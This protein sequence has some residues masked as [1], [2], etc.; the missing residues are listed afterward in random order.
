MWECT[1]TPEGGFVLRDGAA[2]SVRFADESDS[3]AAGEAVR[4]FLGRPR[5]SEIQ[6]AREKAEKEALALR[7]ELADLRKAT[8]KLN[9]EFKQRFV[10]LEMKTFQVERTEMAMALHKERQEFAK[11]REEM[12]QRIN[13]LENREG[14]LI[15]Q[16]LDAAGEA[17]RIAE[18]AVE[19]MLKARREV[20]G[21]QSQPELA[22]ELLDTG[23]KRLA[24]IDAPATKALLLPDPAP[25]V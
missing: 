25:T 2:R 24:E 10:E 23:L 19:H 15:K 8:D 9:G 7:T 21:S 6:A 1:K 12:Q 11:K 20:G 3:H 16:A 13:A 5:L 17:D 14:L 22:R 4:L 18:V